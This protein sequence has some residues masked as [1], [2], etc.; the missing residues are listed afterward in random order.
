MMTKKFLLRSTVA[1]GFVALLSA[2]A[3][4][5]QKTLAAGVCY[6]TSTSGTLGRF[7]GTITNTATTV[8]P[9]GLRC[10][11][12]RDNPGADFVANS[13][14]F[15]VF[16]RHNNIAVVCGVCNEVATSTGIGN[17][18][19][20]L[21]VSSGATTGVQPLTVTTNPTNL[22]SNQYS[23]AEC[24]LPPVASNGGVSHLARITYDE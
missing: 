1:A 21:A 14:K 18:C 4:A 22:G 13:I 12:V 6:Q 3:V 16:D 24:S 23:Y 20:A 5:D 11:L 7:A 10:P 17:N 9:L 19:G 15:D 8:S 2:T